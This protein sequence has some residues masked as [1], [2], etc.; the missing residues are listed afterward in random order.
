VNQEES[1]QEC[2]L[3]STVSVISDPDKLT[4]TSRQLRSLVLDSHFAAEQQWEGTS[5]LKGVRKR[6]K[7]EKQGGKLSSAAGGTLY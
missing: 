5:T 4:N 2:V 6:K 1:E 3:F 7:K